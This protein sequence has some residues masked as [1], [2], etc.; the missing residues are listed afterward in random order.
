MGVRLGNADRC[1]IQTSG[2]GL[3]KAFSWVWE[4]FD[5]L[6]YDLVRRVL[7]WAR[8]WGGVVWRIGALAVVS[9]V[10]GG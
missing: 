10:Y 1:I 9:W 8:R 4:L 5:C 3:H 6:D 2:E 7:L